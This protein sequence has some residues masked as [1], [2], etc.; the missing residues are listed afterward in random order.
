MNERCLK[1]G[2]SQPPIPKSEK[3]CWVVLSSERTGAGTGCAQVWKIGV[4][5]QQKQQQAYEAAA[6]LAC[7]P[8]LHNFHSLSATCRSV[9]FRFW[10]QIPLTAFES[11]CH[12]GCGYLSVKQL[13]RVSEYIFPIKS[14]HIVWELHSSLMILFILEAF[15]LTCK[16][17]QFVF[18][19]PVSPIR[20]KVTTARDTNFYDSSGITSRTVANKSNGEMGH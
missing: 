4:R 6:C 17:N 1:L 2:V 13:H 19:G 16:R 3:S 8:A 9:L 11:I 5:Q 15:F 20:E 10:T 12:P 18:W 14:F 7:P